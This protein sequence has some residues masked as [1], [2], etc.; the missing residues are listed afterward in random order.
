MSRLIV[1]TI[2][3]A[4]AIVPSGCGLLDNLVPQPLTTVRLVNNGQFDVRVTVVFDDEQDA[5]RELL[6]EFGTALEFTLSPGEST[7]FSRD[8]D[9]IQAITL[10]NAELRIIGGVGPGFDSEVFRDG[11]DFNCGDVIEFS[12]DHSDILVDF[13]ADVAILTE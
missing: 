2:L 9:Q 12:F 3:L 5:P 4:I 10:D 6:T 8:C 11:S 7:S 13:D 1:S